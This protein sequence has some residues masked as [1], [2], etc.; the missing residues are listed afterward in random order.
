MFLLDKLK[1]RFLNFFRTF[2]YH[3]FFWLISL[4]FYVFL[5]GNESL[6]INYF[7][8]LLKDDVYGNAV[9]LGVNLAIIFT[10]FDMLFSDKLMRYSPIRFMVLLRFLMYLLLGYLIVFLSANRGVKAQELLDY[11]IYY[12]R[13]PEITLAY[14]RFIV[15]FYVSCLLNSL[16]RGVFRK[17]GVTNFFQ[18]IIG[19][20]NKPRVE[21]RIFMFIDMKSS[22]SI[23]EKLGHKRFSFIVQDVFNELAIVENYHGAI[24]QYLGDGAIISWDLKRGLRNNNCLKAFYAFQNAIH[25]KRLFYDMRYGLVPEFKAGLH[26]GEIMVL[27]VGRFKRDISYNGDTLNTTARIESMCNVHKQNLLISGVLYESLKNKEEFKFTEIKD[28]TVLKGKKQKTQIYKV[29]PLQ[30]KK[31]K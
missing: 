3:L 24:Y 23:A 29:N 30:K 18:W 11:Q 10:F 26:I 17:I 4:S 21:K 6:Y 8:I 25:R 22:V 14:S 7:S 20:M 28:D 31:K 16:F 1:I 15:W 19:T 12:K 9:L 27:Q 5:S 2:F 13:M